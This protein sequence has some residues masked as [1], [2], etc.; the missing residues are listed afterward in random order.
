MRRVSL[1]PASGQTLSR[2]ISFRCVTV[3]KFSGRAVTF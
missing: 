3:N 1:V 2:D